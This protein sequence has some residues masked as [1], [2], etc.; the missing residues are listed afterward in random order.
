[1]TI[2]DA[3]QARIPTDDRSP[4]SERNLSPARGNVRNPAAVETAASKIGR[5]V[6]STASITDSLEGPRESEKAR[7]VT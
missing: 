6:A 1:M 7:S 5:P 2:A 3:A 4:T